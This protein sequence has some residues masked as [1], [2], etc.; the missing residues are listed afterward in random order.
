M[1]DKA[2]KKRNTRQQGDVT[3]AFAAQYLTS[4]GLQLIDKNIHCRQGEID[5]IMT[6]GEIYVFIEVKYRKNNNF[7]GALAAVSYAKQQKIK[8]CVTFYLHQR[9]LNEYN[10]PCRCDVIA[11]TGDIQQPEVDWLKNAF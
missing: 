2:P 3:E 11:L 8:H 9:G 6:D 5:L 7:G 1:F 4:Q 10:T